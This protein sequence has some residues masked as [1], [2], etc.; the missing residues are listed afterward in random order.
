MQTTQ[1]SSLQSLH[2]AQ[3]FPE[4]NTDKLA[5]VVNT[6]LPTVEERGL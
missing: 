5:S 1:R 3:T 6:G 4:P 2:A